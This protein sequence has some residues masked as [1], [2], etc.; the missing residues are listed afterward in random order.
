VGFWRETWESTIHRLRKPREKPIVVHRLCTFGREAE[1]ASRSNPSPVH[2]KRWA[3]SVRVMLS[4]C[5][6]IRR[7]S[8]SFQRKETNMRLTHLSVHLHMSSA[9]NRERR[10]FLQMLTG[11]FLQLALILPRSPQT[12]CRFHLIYYMPPGPSPFSSHASLLS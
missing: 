9:V 1:S 2:K 3:R 4:I 10:Q 5:Q 12:C 6:F 11:Q 8:A 7:S